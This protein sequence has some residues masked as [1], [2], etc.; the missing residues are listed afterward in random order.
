MLEQALTILTHLQEDPNLQHLEIEAR[1]LQQEYNNVQGTM[2]MVALTQ[3]LTRV[4]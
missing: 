4:Q 2:Q 3:R 1:E